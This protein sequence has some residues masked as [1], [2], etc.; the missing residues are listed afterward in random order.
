MIK[1]IKLNELNTQEEI[2]LFLNSIFGSNATKE[3]EPEDEVQ[4][5]ALILLGLYEEREEMIEQRDTLGT[6]IL[7]CEPEWK[8]KMHLDNTIIAITEVIRNFK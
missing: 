1:E 5:P 2:K 3:E 6:F 8:I 4:C 7:P